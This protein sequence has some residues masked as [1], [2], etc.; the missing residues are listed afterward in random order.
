MLMYTLTLLITH[1]KIIDFCR[2][3]FLLIERSINKK[4]YKK[5]LRCSTLSNVK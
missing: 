2:L 5:M 3:Y 4:Y 1:Q